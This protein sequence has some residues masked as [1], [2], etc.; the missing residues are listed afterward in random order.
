[1]IKLD[2]QYFFLKN[3]KPDKPLIIFTG[4]PRNWNVIADYNKKFINR[5][6]ANVIISAWTDANIGKKK[7]IAFKQ[8]KNFLH[9]IEALQ[10]IYVDIEKF[11]V[12]LTYKLFG[13]ITAYDKVLFY[14]ALSTRGQVYK[15]YRSLLIVKALEKLLKKKF[16]VIIKSR[17][18]YLVLNFSLKKNL[19][20]NC[21]YFEHNQSTHYQLSD[22]FF[23]G[24][25]DALFNLSKYLL[26]FAQIV[27]KQKIYNLNHIPINENFFK[28]CFVKYNISYKLI[29]PFSSLWRGKIRPSKTRIFLIILR[30]FIGYLKNKIEFFTKYLH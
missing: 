5:L 10:P 6:D 15:I 4:H 24:S 23:Y 25:R 8:K 9:L 1:L 22:R 20:K 2:N 19:L 13:R 14:C 26:K 17:L 18:D 7:D 3:Y 27:R 30:A 12:K 16:K 28:L 21:I 11:N 29:F